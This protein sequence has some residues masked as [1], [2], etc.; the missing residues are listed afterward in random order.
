MLGGGVGAPLGRRSKALR[1]L[2]GVSLLGTLLGNLEGLSLEGLSFECL[3]GLRLEGLILEGVLEGVLDDLIFDGLPDLILEEDLTLKL[4][5]LF[6]DNLLGILEGFFLD[7]LNLE[8]LTCL[9]D[10]F[11][12][13]GLDTFFLV[14]LFHYE[15]LIF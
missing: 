5:D 13:E 10:F 2:L 15:V 6:F 4:L 9:T 1:I 11:F 7:L 12:E 3:E 8:L 14:T